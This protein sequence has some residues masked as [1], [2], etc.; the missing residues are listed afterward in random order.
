MSND[1]VRVSR[2]RKQVQTF[3][4][5]VIM[6]ILGAVC[7]C[8]AHSIV[9]VFVCL[10]V[11]VF[12]FNLQQFSITL[13]IN[14]Q[15]LLCFSSFLASSVGCRA[16]LVYIWY[17]RI[18]IYCDSFKTTIYLSHSVS[19]PSPSRGILGDHSSTYITTNVKTNCDY[20]VVL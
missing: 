11:S 4:V 5:H 16:D 14:L 7:L 3:V 19:F 1:R 20:I 15:Q 2:S 12:K 8:H 13:R 17:T 18:N 9:Y 10:F 6:R